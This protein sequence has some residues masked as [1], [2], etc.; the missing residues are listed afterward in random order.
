M[1]NGINNRCFHALTVKGCQNEVPYFM[2]VSW[3][4]FNKSDHKVRDV[5]NR[6]LFKIMLLNFV[7]KSMKGPINIS[8]GQSKIHDC[9]KKN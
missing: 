2:Q 7:K 1:N 6:L 3:N 8:F 9:F 4:T 5:E